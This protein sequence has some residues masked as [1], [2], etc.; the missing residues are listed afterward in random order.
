MILATPS[1]VTTKFV[2]LHRMLNTEERIKAEQGHSEL[3]RRTSGRNDKG[4][5]VQKGNMH[6]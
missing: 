2:G 5:K 6:A 1:T 3:R 4:E